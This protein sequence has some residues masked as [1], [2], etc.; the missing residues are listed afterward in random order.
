MNN[1]EEN[2]KELII[3]WK[4][5][6][7]IETF[8]DILILIKDIIFYTPVYVNE[9]FKT[10]ITEKIVSLDGKYFFPAYLGIE[11][12]IMADITIQMKRYS[13]KDYIEIL[14]NYNYNNVERYN[15]RSR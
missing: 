1:K 12:C 10:E 3:E 8:K 4:N 7:S 5:N 9:M 11:D 2:I 14:G 15:Y 6:N 13:L